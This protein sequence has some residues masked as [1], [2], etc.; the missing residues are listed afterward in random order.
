MLGKDGVAGTLVA[1]VWLTWGYLRWLIGCSLLVLGSLDEDEP[2]RVR[3]T[4]S[5]AP[6]ARDRSLSAV[7]GPPV[8]V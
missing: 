1:S 6:L 4:T 5:L 2:C 8:R 7:T 3:G